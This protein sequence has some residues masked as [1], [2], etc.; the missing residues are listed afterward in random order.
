M[1]QGLGFWVGGFG[2]GGPVC[3]LRVEALGFGV[4]CL[5]FRVGVQGFGFLVSGFRVKG[6][7]FRFYG[8][9]FFC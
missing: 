4:Q 2:F 6:L 1:V 8:L 7:R 5:Q 9:V 3:G